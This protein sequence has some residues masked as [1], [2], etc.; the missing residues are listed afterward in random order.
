MSRTRALKPSWSNA[1]T[2]TSLSTSVSTRR[3]ASWA[4]PGFRF[5]KIRPHGPCTWVEHQS[6]A[7]EQPKGAP[8]SQVRYRLRC[9]CEANHAGTW[10]TDQ[11]HHDAR[12]ARLYR[13]AK[14]GP[15][16]SVRFHEG[17]CLDAGGG[18]VSSERLADMGIWRELR[19]PSA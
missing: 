11:Q 10:A 3:R 1:A 9:D 18:R 16:V 19:G 15:A 7:L 12:D 17:D 13:D 5:L 14:Q 2:P 8:S 6:G 4:N